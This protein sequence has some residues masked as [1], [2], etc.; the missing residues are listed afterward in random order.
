[1]LEECLLDGVELSRELSPETIDAPRATLLICGGCGCFCTHGWC[2]FKPNHE[3][4][5][6]KRAGY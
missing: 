5:A 6:R 2:Y 4:E 3:C 1:M